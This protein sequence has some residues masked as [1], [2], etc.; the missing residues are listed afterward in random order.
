M[1]WLSKIPEKCDLCGGKI[2][3]VFYDA[4]TPYGPWALVCHRCYTAHK[5]ATGVGRGQK[6]ETKTGALLKGGRK[7]AM[8]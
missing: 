6:Y 1:N 5:M 2:G 3:R 8:K 4:K 7:E